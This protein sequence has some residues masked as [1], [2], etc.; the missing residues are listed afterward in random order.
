M[1]NLWIMV[2]KP[3]LVE[4]EEGAGASDPGA[5]VHQDA[6]CKEVNML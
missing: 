3:E 6:A 1:T 4:S 5:A 2:V